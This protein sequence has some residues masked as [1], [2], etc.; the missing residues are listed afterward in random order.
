MHG[1]GWEKRKWKR[2]E[3]GWWKGEER[4]RLGEMWGRREG[5]EEGNR[6]ILSDFKIVDEKKYLG[7]VEIQGGNEKGG[8]GGEKKREELVFVGLELEE[9]AF[10]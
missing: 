10:F 1:G 5:G 4:N 3:K 7:F 6:M 2:G 8:G 9:F